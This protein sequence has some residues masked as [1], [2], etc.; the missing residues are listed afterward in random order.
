MSVDVLTLAHELLVTAG[1]ALDE[2]PAPED[3]RP[4]WIAMGSFFLLF[5]V[6]ILLWLSMRK[7]LGRI[8]FDDGVERTPKQPHRFPT[9]EPGTMSSDPA[10]AP[11]AEADSS[12]GDAERG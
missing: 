5:A 10:H 1:D 2:T 3:V 8:K 9:A 12:R 11:S 6:T 7:Q 4:G